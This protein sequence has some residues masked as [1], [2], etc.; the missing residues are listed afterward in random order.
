M[1]KKPN[2]FARIIGGV[3]RRRA[4]LFRKMIYRPVKNKNI[5]KNAVL[6]ES[7][8]GKVIGDSPLDIF[9]ELKVKHPDLKLIWSYKRSTLKKG[10]KIPAGAVGVRHGSLAWLNALARSKYLVNNTAFPWY[11]KK[12]AGQ[13]YLQ[14][15]HGTPLKRLVLDIEES[16]L[17]PQYLATM[18]RE[19]ASWDYLIS[20]SDYASKV[21]ESAFGYRG[22]MI[23]AGYPRNDRVVRA[24]LETRNRVRRELGNISEATVLVL[25]APTWRE[26]NRNAIGDIKSVNYLEPN[27]ELP[28]GFKM[29]YRAHSMTQA[30]HG[31]NTAGG[32]IDVTNYPD[33][34][35]LFLAAD[36]LITD[37][38]SV[39]FDFA[40]TDKPIIFLTPDIEKYEAERGFYF[41]L[42][43]QAP[44]PICKNTAEV[45]EALK[46]TERAPL[47][48]RGNYESWKK[49]FTGL[50]DGSAAARV[51]AQVFG[52]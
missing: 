14:T 25:Y 34:A 51:V 23:E 30:T 17:S 48:Y 13:I 45:I 27:T 21:F 6:F 15:W 35:E 39:M 24:S 44:G 29:M 11:F 46:D 8:E 32:A 36:V 3:R 28:R 2:N 47:V 20:P 12:S 5:L 41:D 50:D 22:R 26:Y 16:K 38:S 31:K 33:I 1:K 10:A 19:A 18:K 4:D 52:N 42:R 49:K 37:Y 9:N 40:I 43:A 7:F